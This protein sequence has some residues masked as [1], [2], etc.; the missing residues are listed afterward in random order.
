MIDRPV[1]NYQPQNKNKMYHHRTDI[2]NQMNIQLRQ[3]EVLRKT[4]CL[5]QTTKQ[6]NARV[7]EDKET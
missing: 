5:E 3:H 6:A 7:C 4:L 2:L 1:V